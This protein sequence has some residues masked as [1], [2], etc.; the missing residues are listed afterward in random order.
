M[1]W[2]RTAA[3]PPSSPCL[4]RYT[5]ILAGRWLSTDLLLSRVAA[6]VGRR[7]LRGKADKQRDGLAIGEPNEQCTI[8]IDAIVIGETPAI[9]LH[10]VDVVHT[11]L[12]RKAKGR[13]AAGV[14]KELAKGDH[15]RPLVGLGAFDLSVQQ[16]A[17]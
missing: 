6:V 16:I 5:R 2:Q 15:H 14:A 1:S 10:H 12:R 8:A 13:V 11:Q 3:A 7:R 9:A 17:Q 4:T